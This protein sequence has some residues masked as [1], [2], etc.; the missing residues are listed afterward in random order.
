MY[1]KAIALAKKYEYKYID[2]GARI[3]QKFMIEQPMMLDQFQKLSAEY[4]IKLLLPVLT[5]END[6]MEIEEILSA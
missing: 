1:L 6:E 2:E 4:G 5:L 3:S